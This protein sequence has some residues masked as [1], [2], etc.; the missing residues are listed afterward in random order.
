[1]AFDYRAAF[2]ELKPLSL[3]QTS[4]E[5]AEITSEAGGTREGWKAFLAQPAVKQEIEEDIEELRQASLHS[6]IADAGDSNSV[7]KA[8]LINSLV[9]YG[10]NQQ[11]AQGPIIYYCHIPLTSEELHSP[12]V[13]R[14]EGRKVNR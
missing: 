9:S 6:L 7:G 3:R 2:D 5:L 8:N 4:Y 10:K 13:A 11:G 14:A 1:M 12:V